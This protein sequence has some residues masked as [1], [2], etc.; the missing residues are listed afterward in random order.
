MRGNFWQAMQTL[1]QP[2]P[3]R[4]ITLTVCAAQETTPWWRTFVA[5]IDV[6]QSALRT[7]LRRDKGGSAVCCTARD[8]L[9]AW[10]AMSAHASQLL[11][12]VVHCCTLKSHHACCTAL[13]PRTR[14]ASNRSLKDTSVNARSANLHHREVHAGVPTAR[15][16]HAASVP[17]A[18]HSCS[19][20]KA[21]RRYRRLYITL[22]RYSYVNTLTAM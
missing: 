1:A 4:C 3:Q 19:R 15:V 10:R 17:T 13:P 7:R 21:E 8:P 12:W 14:L 9:L 2:K 5:L 11:W 6:F 20:T 16:S 22:S 18:L